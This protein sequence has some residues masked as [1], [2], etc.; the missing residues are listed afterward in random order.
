LEG[1]VRLTTK[2]TKTRT[3]IL[4][5]HEKATYYKSRDILSV[6]Q[7]NTHFE[8]AWLRGE[9]VFRSARFSEIIDKLEKR[10]GID[11]EIHGKDYDKDLFTGN[12]KE[13]YVNNI[14]KILQIH[15]NFTYTETNGKIL[16]RFN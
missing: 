1:S 7:T 11:I 14:L 15:Y 4:S 12:F 5:P 3:V 8:T 16:V 13:D 6:S 9:L 2:G 10:Y